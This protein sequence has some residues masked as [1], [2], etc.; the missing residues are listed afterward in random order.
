VQLQVGDVADGNEANSTGGATQ[1]SVATLTDDYILGSDATRSVH[2]N[3]MPAMS[4]RPSGVSSSS[5]YG[6][7]KKRQR[8]VSSQAG[9]GPRGSPVDFKKL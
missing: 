3:F 7:L 9:P 6:T 4:P 8:V 5:V 2:G 1:R